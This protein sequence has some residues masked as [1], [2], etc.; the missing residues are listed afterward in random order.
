MVATNTEV[1]NVV[2]RVGN[3]L[4]DINNSVEGGNHELFQRADAIN[5]GV[6]KLFGGVQ[7]HLDQ[8]NFGREKLDNMNLL[9][10]ADRPINVLRDELR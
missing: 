8:I 5:M 6:N 9:D 3:G 4:N 10:V 7:L 1:N 2:G